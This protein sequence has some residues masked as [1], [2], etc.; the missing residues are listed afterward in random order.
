MLEPR[1]SAK[2]SVLEGLAETWNEANVCYAVTNGLEG[3]PSSIGRDL[4]VCVNRR[5]LEKTRELTRNYLKKKGFSVLEFKH[6]WLYWIIGYRRTG[7][8]ID[9]VQI[10]LFDHLQWAFTW[11]V[12]VSVGGTFGTRQGPFK[13]CAEASVAKRI[14]LNLLAGNF[15]TFETKPHYLITTLEERKALGSVLRRIG[16]IHFP[17]VEKGIFDQDLNLLT[18]EVPQ[19]RKKV[20]LRSVFNP[21]KILARFWCAWLKQW[22]INLFPRKKAPIIILTTDQ[23][24]DYSNL[25]EFVKQQTLFSC[26]VTDYSTLRNS[27]IGAVKYLKFLYRF[28]YQDRK[29]S[30][31]QVIQIYK[32]YKE[33]K[34]ELPFPFGV[35]QK[36]FQPSLDLALEFESDLSGKNSLSCFVVEE[37]MDYFS[38]NCINE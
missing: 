15:S 34:S 36:F 26:I 12:E 4:D 32:K 1:I 7:E 5:E 22:A 2:I 6:A 17:K 25:E 3:Y 29:I 18:S 38:P 23:Q 21:R 31:A 16:G 33:N 19:L 30:S 13:V 9:A 24:C 28:Q 14:I 27:E 11:V 10:D 35:I 8:R 20:V 37:L